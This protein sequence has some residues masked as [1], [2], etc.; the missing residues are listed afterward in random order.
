MQIAKVKSSKGLI[1]IRAQEITE[2]PEGDNIKQIEVESREEP[3]AEFHAAMGDL[4]GPALRMV[5]APEAWEQ[6]ATISGLSITHEEDRG[7]G[8]VVTLLIP[9]ECAPSPLVI[10]TPYLPSHGRDE[11]D[12]GPCL[13][14]ALVRAV[15]RVHDEALAYLGG[16]RAP[17]AQTDLFAAPEPVSPLDTI[18]DE[19]ARDP[20]PPADDT[21]DTVTFTIPGREPVT[22]N[23]AGLKAAADRLQSGGI[24]PARGRRPA[25]PNAEIH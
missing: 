20:A 1:T 16:E 2:G 9:L 3:R 21:R 18:A 25:R 7:M 10:N 4:I 12:T 6:V 14:S 15:E 5:E 23:M 13:P 19:L 11:N 8:A 22:T 17:S 24:R